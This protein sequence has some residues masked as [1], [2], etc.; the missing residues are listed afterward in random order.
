MTKQEARDHA[1]ALVRAGLRSGDVR[2]Q[3]VHTCTL[4]AREFATEAAWEAHLIDGKTTDPA[5]G[6]RRRLCPGPYR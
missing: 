5:T 1:M 3:F 6:K 2:I 4:C